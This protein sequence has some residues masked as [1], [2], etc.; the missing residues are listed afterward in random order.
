MR[1]EDS[2][3]RLVAIVVSVSAL[4]LASGAIAQKPTQDQTTTNVESQNPH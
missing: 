2:H 1:E 3:M 4:T